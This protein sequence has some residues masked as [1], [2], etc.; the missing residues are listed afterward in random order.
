M[1]SHVSQPNKTWK[2]QQ[3]L[4]WP[5]KGTL[6]LERT[7][8]CKCDSHLTVNL[9]LEWIILWIFQ[10]NNTW[11]A[12]PLLLPKLFVWSL[13]LRNALFYKVLALVMARQRQEIGSGLSLLSSKGTFSQPFKEKMY[14]HEVATIGS[15]IIAH[16]SKL[17]KAKFFILRDVIFLLRLQGKFDIV[18]SWE[19]KA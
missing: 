10:Q 9:L 1:P 4:N 3:A 11:V 19:R 5:I 12:S 14:K 7:S 18:L 16:L 8:A 15:I 6:L 2:Y 17:W 13:L